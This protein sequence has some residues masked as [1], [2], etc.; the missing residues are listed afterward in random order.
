MHLTFRGRSYSP[1]VS[2]ID[3]AEPQTPGI[4]R[5]VETKVGLTS[6]SSTPDAS[7]TLTY[8]GTRYIRSL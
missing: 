3:V 1:A 7:A 2:H 5:G 8:R 4:Y 6:K